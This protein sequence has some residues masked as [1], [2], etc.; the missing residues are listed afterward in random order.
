MVMYI[1]GYVYNS[2]ADKINNICIFYEFCLAIMCHCKVQ[3]QV[4]RMKYL[5][6]SDS[7]WVNCDQLHIVLSQVLCLLPAI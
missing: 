6:K 3:V 5:F 7:A 4:L 2:N 1:S